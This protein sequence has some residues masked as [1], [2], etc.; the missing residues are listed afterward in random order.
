[1]HGKH[2]SKNVTTHRAI[3]A[4]QWLHPTIF[5]LH[6]SRANRVHIHRC[7]IHLSASH[8]NLILD[9]LF[10]QDFNYREKYATRLRAPES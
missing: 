9:M 1:M 5:P 10:L 3:N 8:R 2:S 4:L 6:F 7:E